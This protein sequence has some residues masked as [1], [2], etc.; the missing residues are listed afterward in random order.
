M[1]GHCQGGMLDRLGGE[2][3]REGE[4]QIAVRG[5]QGGILCRE[6]ELDEKRLS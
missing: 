5:S 4:V 6:G 1:R 3:K 2:D